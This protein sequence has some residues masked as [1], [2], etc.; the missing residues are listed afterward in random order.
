LYKLLRVHEKAKAKA[1]LSDLMKLPKILFLIIFFTFLIPSAKACTTRDW[2][3]TLNIGSLKINDK[4][5]ENLCDR[6]TCYISEDFIVVKSSYDGRVAIILGKTSSILG[7]KGITFRLPYKM[8]EDNLL[9]IS[10]V[11]PEKYDWENLVKTDLNFLKEL[12]IIE[13]SSKDVEEISS[14]ATNGKN[15]MFCNSSWQVLEPNC[16]CE[17][18]ILCVRCGTSTF[19]VEIPKKLLTS[20]TQTLPSISIFIVTLILVVI[21]VRKLKLYY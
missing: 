17:G 15:I 19:N 5:L 20:K 2:R 8:N 18:D 4:I 10:E 3:F 11:D 9:E 21:A 1:I 13:I 7:F 14:L 6:E 16:F 12:G